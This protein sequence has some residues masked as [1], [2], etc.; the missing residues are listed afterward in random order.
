MSQSGLLKS[1]RFAPFFFTQFLG[2][3]NDN[4]Y[5]N[6]L[7][8]IMTY[9]AADAMGLNSHIVLNLA[10]V[11][12]ILPFL[13][14]SALA[15]QIADKYEKSALIRIIK[16]FE[17]VIM[18]AGAAALL[19][20]NYVALLILLFL[21]GTQSAFFGPCKYAILPQHLGRHELVGGNALVEMG[22]FV[23]ILLATIGAGIILQF[24]NYLI[25]ASLLVVFLACL[26][27]LSSYFIP[28][29]EAI[30]SGLK[31]DF[32]II[33]SSLNLVSYARKNRGI[34]L[35]IL[36]ISWFWF[37]GASYLTQFPNFS[38]EVL[39][40]DPSLVTLLL[41]IFTLG[42]GL[43]SLLCEKL[44]R[45][46]VELG[47]VPIGALGMT[48]FGVDLYIAIPSEL[49][50]I[51]TWFTFISNSNSWRMLIDLAGIGIFGGIF[52]V[53]LYAYIQLRVE[54]EYRARIIGVINII[55]ALFLVASGLVAMMFLGGF[56]LTISEFFLVISVMN[57]VVSLFIFYQVDEFAVRFIVWILTN[58]IYRVKEQGRDNIPEEGAA[59]LVSNH[60]SFVDALLIASTS[61]RPIR[62]VMDHNIFKNPLLGWFFRLVKA[63]PIAPEKACEKTY[64]DAFDTISQ[65]LR[66]GHLVCIF[67]EGKL[68]KTGEMNEFKSGI[69]KIIA[70]DPVPVIPIALI[71]L[72][73]SFF[74]H[75]EGTALSKPPKRF[76]SRV[77]IKIAPFMTPEKVNASALYQEVERLMK[78]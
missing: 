24:E 54:E 60:V 29:A 75:K 6:T 74:S 20:E 40:G 12:F 78:A 13:L 22:T 52:I 18:L 47:I 36:A 62:F 55:N 71:G 26:G 51:E 41:A 64:K 38:K 34:Y 27:Y 17:I 21:M 42:I 23:S 4:I 3:F 2:A 7:M 43:G 31:L 72:W 57:I 77:E 70:S 63:I 19:T 8:L 58:I 35:A 5:K 44:S 66:E 10:A 56:D 46:Q 11:L 59:I 53:P 37:L 32:N 65:V 50:E 33:K 45:K 28:K 67:P 25:I 49:L 48:L 73:G 15:G 16:F 1:K 14:F 9:G 76:W 30:D 39:H 68:T 69:D 61:P